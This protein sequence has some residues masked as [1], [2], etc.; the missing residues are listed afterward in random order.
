MDVK[1]ITSAGGPSGF[2]IADRPEV[3][4]AGRSNAGK[5]S[6]INTLT[7]RKKLARTS[8]TPGRTRLINFFA[9]GEEVYFVDLPGYGFARV[10]VSVR[11]S[12]MH[13]VE[14]YLEIR[15]TLAAVVVIIDIR[16]E[17]SKGDIDLLHRLKM[18]GIPAIPALTKSDKL[19]RGKAAEKRTAVTRSL[20]ELLPLPPVVFSSKTREGRDELW[21]QI[22][23]LTSTDR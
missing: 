10:P 21:G 22:N 9:V 3:A 14:T 13:L 5:S 2:P 16:R 12:W 17:P 18:R 1:F 4:F 7:N 11:K 19:S 20:L 6:L 8:G 15:P 23:K